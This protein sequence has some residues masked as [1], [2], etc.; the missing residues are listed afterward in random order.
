[1]RWRTWEARHP[2]GAP[3]P[4]PRTAHPDGRSNVGPGDRQQGDGARQ[5]GRHQVA[6]MPL[7]AELLLEAAQAGRVERRQGPPGAAGNRVIAAHAETGPLIAWMTRCVSYTTWQDVA[8]NQRFTQSSTPRRPSRPRAA[9]VAGKEPPIVRCAQLENA[10]LVTCLVRNASC[11]SRDGVT[12]DVPCSR[13]LWMATPTCHRS[14]LV[15]WGALAS[16]WHEEACDGDVRAASFPG[17]GASVAPGAA[18][19]DDRR[20]QSVGAASSAR[21]THRS[22]RFWRAG[23]VELITCAGSTGGTWVGGWGAWRVRGACGRCGL[24]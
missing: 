11:V 14:M 21:T 23:S 16:P 12:L 5:P 13:A 7:R 4:L 20:R 15:A 22:F 10:A 18:H 9:F 19:S 6:V 24:A 8:R 2:T 1:M 17:E 3:C